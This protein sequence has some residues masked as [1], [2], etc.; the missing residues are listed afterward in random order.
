MSC[1][2]T[3]YYSKVSSTT[4]STTAIV[5][6]LQ[7]IS[8]LCVYNNPIISYTDCTVKLPN[9]NAITHLLRSSNGLSKWIVCR[10]T[11]ELKPN[12]SLFILDV[13]PSLSNTN[14]NTSRLSRCAWPV[15]KLDVPI[16]GISWAQIAVRIGM[17][18]K[19][20]KNGSHPSPLR[21]IGYALRSCRS[22]SIQRVPG[23]GRAPNACWKSCSSPAAELR[24]PN[25]GVLGLIED[26]LNALITP[27]S[28]YRF[29]KAKQ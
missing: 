8:V 24:D 18:L 22:R 15:M 4:T 5:R 20:Q 25:A 29:T 6:S 11:V 1:C 14:M 3:I 28:H 2:T 26:A 13:N 7:Y 27:K 16:R 23:W 12:L 9:E 21:A 19:S 10:P 17:S